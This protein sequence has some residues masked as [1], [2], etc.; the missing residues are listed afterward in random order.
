LIEVPV[1]LED[2]TAPYIEIGKSRDRLVSEAG[3]FGVEQS[4]LGANI[5]TIG[6]RVL[7]LVAKSEHLLIKCR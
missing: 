6:Y 7:S 5:S 4:P 2:S 1:R 3:T